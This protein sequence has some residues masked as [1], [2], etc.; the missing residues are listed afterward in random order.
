VNPRTVRFIA[1]NRIYIFVVVAFALALVLVPQ[2]QGVLPIKNLV[3]RATID[4]IMAVG[5]TV[6]LLSG[7]LDLSVGSI[8]ALSG[9]VALGLQGD[10]G[11]I[12]AA[13]AGILAGGLVGVINGLLVVKAGI[14]SF[15]V[16][17]ASMIAVRGVAMTISGAGPIRGADSSFGPS[18]DRALFGPIWQDLPLGTFLTPRILIFLALLVVAHVILL[19]VRQGRNVYA[20]GGNP[21]AARLSGID[22]PLYT[23]GAFVFCGLTAGLSGTLLGLSMNTGTPTVG[24]AGALPVIAAVVI[25]GTALTGGSGSMLKTLMGVLLMALVSTAMNLFG[26]QVYLQNVVLGLVLILVVL[27]DAIYGAWRTRLV[28]AGQPGSTRAGP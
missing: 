11:P 25:G 27:L 17:L 4:G 10:I 23:L 19:R 24:G 6:V 15:I 13:V 3:Q 7:Q 28:I 18:V 22:V 8:L 5:M 16:T 9:V 2:L 21:E 14:N 1:E 26:L 20:V 12:P